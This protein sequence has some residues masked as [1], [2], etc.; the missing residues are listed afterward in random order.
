M[1]VYAQLK[2]REHRDEKEPRRV[3]LLLIEAEDHVRSLLDYQSIARGKGTSSEATSGGSGGLQSESRPQEGSAQERGSSRAKFCTKCG[4]QF[5]G[6]EMF[7]PM[8]G[9]ERATVTNTGT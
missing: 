8:C 7:C 3:A 4:F 1:Y 6:E 9:T 5:S 2:F